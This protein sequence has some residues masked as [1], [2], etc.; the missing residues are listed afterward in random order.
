MMNGDVEQGESAPQNGGQPLWPQVR[1]Q[2][3]EELFGGEGREFVH[4]YLVGVEDP[5]PDDTSKHAKN[6]TP[7]KLIT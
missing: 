3:M 1:P 7:S 6:T 5:P 2:S 4:K